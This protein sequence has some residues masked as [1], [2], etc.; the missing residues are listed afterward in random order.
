M[1]P[2]NLGM[3]GTSNPAAA[4]QEIERA[5]QEDA[6]VYADAMEVT[7]FTETRTLDMATASATD[8]GNFLATFVSDCKKRGQNRTQPT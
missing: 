8:I 6:L 1:R 7:G 2:I 3:L 5:S 4:F